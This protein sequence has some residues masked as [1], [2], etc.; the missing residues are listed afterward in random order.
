MIALTQPDAVKTIHEKYLEAG[1]DIIETNTFSSTSIGNGR[2]Q[3]GT[4]SL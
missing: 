4:F 1:A 2:L 3:H